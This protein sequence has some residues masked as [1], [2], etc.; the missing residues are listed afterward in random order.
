MLFLGCSHTQAAKHAYSAIMAA[1][2]TA[3]PFRHLC[4]QN[5]FPRPYYESLVDHWP[6]LAK[7]PST[8]DDGSPKNWK[9]RKNVPAEKLG[10]YWSD[11]EK[12][13]APVL[14]TALKKKF[15]IQA[16]SRTRML[17]TE[18]EPSFFIG[19]HNDDGMLAQ[20]LL[21]V[22]FGDESGT[23]LYNEHKEYVKEVPA[24]PN[25]GLAFAPSNVSWHSV[26]ESNTPRHKITFRLH[27]R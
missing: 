18:D 27:A 4:V 8:G 3:V 5:V 1:S 24:A 19:V 11:F 25:A 12:S 20:F 2:F 23:Y 17:I 26:P 6:D 22:P 13:L 21:Y 14:E 15:D 7:F 9:L 16:V 10:G